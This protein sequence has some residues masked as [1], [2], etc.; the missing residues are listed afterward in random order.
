M[1][2]EDEDEGSV[3]RLRVLAERVVL[4]V[5][6]LSAVRTLMAVLEA[7]DGAG[8]GL[9]AGGLAYAALI[10]LLPGLLLMLSIFGLLIGDQAAR[11]QIVAVIANAVPPL[12]EIA[13]TAFEQVSAGAVP[14]GV[15]AFVGLLWGASRFY[16]ALDYAFARI[17]HGARRRNEIERTFRGVVVTGLIVALPLGALIAGSLASWVLELAPNL[18]IPVVVWAL[19]Q[20]ATPAGSFLLFVTGTALV[21]R[22]VPGDR[23]PVRAWRLPAILVGIVLA[24][25]TQVFTFIAPRLTHTAAIY[26]TFVTFFAILAWLSISFNV[27][28]FG[29]S[30]TRV[31]EVAM[32]RQ[33]VPSTGAEGPPEAP[34]DATGPVSS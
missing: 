26:G 2:P 13:R 3:D 28:L 34:A 16:A 14:T 30:W 9:M 15:I 27:L 8:G 7:Y 33:G 12:E 19:F 1:S 20:L 18:E 5:G 29:A 25:F 4:R 17:F 10:A 24:A 31:R 21:F 32:A 6:G 23:V 22:F 11:E